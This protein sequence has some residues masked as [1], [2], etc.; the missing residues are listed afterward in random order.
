[1]LGLTGRGRTVGYELVE[2]ASNGPAAQAGLKVGDV[3]TRIGGRPTVG[4]EYLQQAL[5]ERD[6]GQEVAVDYQRGAAA[7]QAM[8]KLAPRVP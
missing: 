4:D 8:L 5:A 3:L 1:M 2:L 6:A 7:A